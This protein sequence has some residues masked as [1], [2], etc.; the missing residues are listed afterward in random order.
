MCAN[1]PW[2]LSGAQLSRIREARPRTLP[3][4]AHT[5]L[6]P[7]ADDRHLQPHRGLGRA[8]YVRA[9]GTQPVSRRTL[10]GERCA[11]YKHCTVTLWLT[12]HCTVTLHCHQFSGAS[13]GAS[14]G[15]TLAYSC[16]LWR[17]LLP[18][19]THADPRITLARFVAVSAVSSGNRHKAVEYMYVV[20][21]AR[22]KL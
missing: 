17:L 20:P 9:A 10:S 11:L 2:P 13:S 15:A 7:Q 3:T 5:Q 6:H 1:C 16:P 4:A 12:L 22:S 14:S 8:L 19:L 21:A 18:T